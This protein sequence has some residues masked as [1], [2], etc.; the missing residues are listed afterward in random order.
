MKKFKVFEA[1]ETETETE[2]EEPSPNQEIGNTE[3]KKSTTPFLDDF[4]KDLTKM[5]EEDK[6]E[7]VYGRQKEI[8]QILLILGRKTKN[9]PVL[10]GEPGVGKT[11]LIEGLAQ[12][13]V[14]GKCPTSMK[15]KRIVYID[16]GSLIA[17]ASK[18]GEFEKRVKILLSEL[19]KNKNIILFIDE[20]HMMVN[21][22]MTIDAANMFKP[23][24][25][26]GDM[27]LIGATTLNEY[28]NSVEKD[29]ALERRF[30]KVMIEEPSVEETIAILNRI[31]SRFEDFHLV[32]YSE[33]AIDACVKL[34]HKYMTDRFFPDKAID[35]LDEVGAKARLLKD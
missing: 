2:H 14:K 20:I 21:P 26:R 17:G 6:L 8:L 35:L 4:G 16:M 25:S 22:S 1:G 9:N 10:I 7:P 27:R 15:G 19:E 30:Q 31:K 13:I 29:G 18:Q 12:M 5:A 24:L 3:K 28:R 33:D 34:S 11:A 23:A 32:R